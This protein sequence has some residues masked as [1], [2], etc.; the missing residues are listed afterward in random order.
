ME[1]QQLDRTPLL[2]PLQHADIPDGFSFHGVPRYYRQALEG[3][4]RAI[5][6]FRQAGVEFAVHLGD[7]SA[8]FSGPWCWRRHF[9]CRQPVQC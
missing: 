1:G 6:H 3:L 4:E 2:C 9:S 7:V 5:D 8:Y